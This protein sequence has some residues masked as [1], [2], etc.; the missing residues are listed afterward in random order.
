[1]DEHKIPC[2]LLFNLCYCILHIVEELVNSLHWTCIESCYCGVLFFACTILLLN[3]CVT[4]EM[5]L[6][7]YMTVFLFENID[8]VLFHSKVEFWRVQ[9]CL[10]FDFNKAVLC[11]SET[12]S[13]FDHLIRGVELI[14]TESFKSISLLV[15]LL[16][17][18]QTKTT[19]GLS[20]SDVMISGMSVE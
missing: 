10:K 14:E 7:L 20:S 13:L 17:D 1:M 9:K 19:S 6:F 15:Q 8:S 4:V 12:R 3:V 5:T 11:L 16:V 2:W 18:W